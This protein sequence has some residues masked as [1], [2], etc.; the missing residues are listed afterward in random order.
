MCRFGLHARCHRLQYGEYFRRGTPI[1]KSRPPDKILLT[2]VTHI[3]ERAHLG[4]AQRAMLLAVA[5]EEP[6]DG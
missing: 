5:R 2:Q 4:F 6:F 3:N 1:G